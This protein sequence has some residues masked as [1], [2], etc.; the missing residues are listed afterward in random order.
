MFVNKNIDTSNSNTIHSKKSNTFFQP[1]LSINQPNDIY[2]RQADA[3][4]ERIMRMPDNATASQ[5]FFKPAISP[6]RSTCA[7][8]GEE[9]KNCSGRK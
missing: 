5:P 8:C 9:E 3:M 7:H 6:V 2:E 1:Q 4:T